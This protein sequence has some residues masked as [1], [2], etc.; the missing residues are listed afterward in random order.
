MIGRVAGGTVGFGSDAIHIFAGGES[1]GLEIRFD[2]A[3]PIAPN[4]T[5]LKPSLTNYLLGSNP[6]MWRKH[7]SNYAKVVYSGLYSGVDAVF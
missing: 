3:Q 5:D 2:G 1:D 6:T 7:V 4:G